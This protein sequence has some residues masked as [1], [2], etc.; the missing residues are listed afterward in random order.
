MADI[1]NLVMMHWIDH[2][3]KECTSFYT[4]QNQTAGGT[5][6]YAGL[7]TALQDCS[8]AGLVAI[9]FQTTLQIGNAPVTGPYQSVY[10][11]AAG[12]S[13]ILT[14]GNPFRWS[15]PAPKAAIFES[16]TKT[17]KLSS[18]QII[19]LDTEMQA[20]LGNSSGTGVGPIAYGNR[21]RAGGGP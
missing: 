20:V 9:Q 15:I 19:A 7:G 21:T 17:L 3:G 2:N 16:D 18:A 11:R 12:M 10:D 6:A 13:H 1:Y 5:G 14:S 4:T 8:D